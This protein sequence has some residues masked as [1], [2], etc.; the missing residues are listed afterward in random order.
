MDQRIQ[1][2]RSPACQ[3]AAAEDLIYISV[4]SGGAMIKISAAERPQFILGQLIV[5]GA[6]ILVVMLVELAS[7]WVN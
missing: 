3:N 7:W 1:A 2:R 4:C 6:A 5:F